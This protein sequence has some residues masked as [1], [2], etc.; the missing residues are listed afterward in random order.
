[1]TIDAPAIQ[2]HW[3][4]CSDCGKLHTIS[5]IGPRTRCSCEHVLWVDLVYLY[6]DRKTPF[7]NS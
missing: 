2:L 7:L 3:L 1:M 4:R 5:L 6:T